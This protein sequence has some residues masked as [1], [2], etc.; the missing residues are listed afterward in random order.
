MST[1]H[2]AL[3][4]NEEL[5]LQ[6]RLIV[7][8]WLFIAFYCLDLDFIIVTCTGCMQDDLDYHVDVTD[9][10]LRVIYIISFTSYIFQYFDVVSLIHA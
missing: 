4:V 6:T 2:I 5:S 10:R 9:S 7:C 1:K 8:H 3:A